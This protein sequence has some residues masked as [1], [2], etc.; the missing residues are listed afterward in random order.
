MLIVEYCPHGNLQSYL[1]KNRQYFVDQ[2]NREEDQIDRT[3]TNQK[4]MS[5]NCGSRYVPF[6][7]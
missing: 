6:E 5:N 1:I 2:L 4:Q 3:I 7:G